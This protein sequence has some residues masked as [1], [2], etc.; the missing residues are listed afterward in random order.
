[1]AHGVLDKYDVGRVGSGGGSFILWV[2]FG[3]VCG[4]GWVKETGCTT[5]S[6][7]D[8]KNMFVSNL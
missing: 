8:E 6:L 3:W 5:N 4:L 7:P 1:M 2:G